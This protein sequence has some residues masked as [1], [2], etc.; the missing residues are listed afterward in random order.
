MDLDVLARMESEIALEELL[1]REKVEVPLVDLKLLVEETRALRRLFDV[2]ARE[3]YAI[4]PDI[5]EGTWHLVVGHVWATAAVG[6]GPTLGAATRELVNSLEP[7][8]PEVVRLEHK[9]Q[10]A[11]DR[12][13]NLR[14]TK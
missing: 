13:R 2:S 6:S 11:L 10:L 12:R 1:T 3:G 9:L 7:D 5:A 8:A 14:A 4:E